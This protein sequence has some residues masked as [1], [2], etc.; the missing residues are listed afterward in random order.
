MLTYQMPYENAGAFSRAL[1]DIR[2]KDPAGRA[3]SVLFYITWVRNAR[4]LVYEVAEQIGRVFP[5]APWY[6]CEASGNI[7]DGR[8]SYGVHVTCWA[9][10]KPDTYAELV[11]LQEGTAISSM[12]DLWRL[13]G[14]RPGLRGVELIPSSTYRDLF[15]LDGETAELDEGIIIFGGASVDYDDPSIDAD[16]IA[17][18]HPMT[19][20]GMIA[21]LYYGTELNIQPAYVL[22]WKGLGRSMR[23][24]GSEGK[25]IREIDGQPAFSIYEKYLNLS[26]S[27]HDALVFPLIME[28]DGV[29]FIRTPTSFLPDYSIRMVI[30]IPEG[31]R[32]RISYGDRN[33]ILAGLY[34]KISDIAAFSPQ[35]IKIY[36]CAARRLFWGDSQVSRETM[37]LTEIASVN[38]FYTGGELLRFGKKLRVMNSTLVIVSFRE[39]SA[40]R[41]KNVL[42]GQEER[43]DKSL[44]SRLAYFTA[45]ITAEQAQQYAHEKLR[46]DVTGYMSTHEGD[47]VEMLQVFAE[48]LR[49]LYAADQVTY[50]DN[51]GTRF[52]SDIPSAARM[53]EGCRQKCVYADPG[54]QV[55]AD[56]VI[57][58]N[59]SLLVKDDVLPA[60]GCPVRA[61]LTRVVYCD[62]MP[63]G[64][65][66][67]HYT[68]GPH[69]FSDL[70][71]G[72]LA[73]FARILSLAIS[74]Y[75]AKQK[76]AL[77]QEQ[78]EQR[79]RQHE[80]GLASTLDSLS[81]DY[82]YVVYADIKQKTLFRIRS[83]AEFDALID[84]LD[85]ALS[86]SERLDAFFRNAV[87]PEDYDDFRRFTS[88]ERVRRYVSQGKACYH[89][90]R[91]VHNGKTEYYRIKI[92]PARSSLD[93]FVIGLLNINDDW[94]LRKKL[95]SEEKQLESKAII[96][97]FSQDFESISY[98]HI[99]P[100]KAWDVAVPYRVSRKLTQII[101]EWEQVQSY[102]DRLHLLADR[103]V[104][105]VDRTAF[106]AK[107]TC[108]VILT[109]LKHSDS[110][111]VSF[112]VDNGTDEYAYYQM[113]FTPV[114]DADGNMN[115]IISGLRNTDEETRRELRRQEEITGIVEERTAD[116]M[117]ANTTL[118]NISNNVLE[119]MADLVESRSAESG[120]H[121][122]RVKGFTEI[123]A[124]CVMARCPGYGLT[125]EKV[126]TIIHAS[127][128]HDIG[129]ITIPDNVLLKPG[130]LTDGEFARMK[131]HSARGAEIVRK[132]SGIWDDK[133]ISVASDICM[134]H[135]EKWDGR[136]YPSGLMGDDIPIAAQIVSIA[137]IYDALTN[138][139]CYKPAYTHDQAFDMIVGGQCGAFSER[140]LACFSAC[141]EM[142]R[143]YANNPV[144][145]LPPQAKVDIEY[146][147]PMYLR[148]QTFLADTMPLISAIAEN[149]PGAFFVYRDNADGLLVYCNAQMI[150]LA[151]CENPDDF[152][153]YT[154]NTMRG[155]VHPDD[156]PFTREHGADETSRGKNGQ[157]SLTYRIVRKNGEIVRLRDYRTFI[158]SADLGNLFFVS[159]NGTA[160]E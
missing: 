142:F 93:N 154:G 66:S 74:R 42:I 10:E 114:R 149:M 151:G 33:T 127:A 78:E 8:L 62:D 147:T 106:L 159:V 122:R 70:E 129:K 76:N 81:E 94:L 26:L 136:G 19:L 111:F 98:V 143:N 140:M 59:D 36:S 11:W 7:A 45:Q 121:I 99:E 158:R 47:P 13:C 107:T 100:E 150:R 54:H 30:G 23:V 102:M 97:S 155:L 146:K 24:S 80:A 109:N 29:E 84:A 3:G 118:N 49:Q 95:E 134:Y 79:R 96:D 160:E 44:V 119:L 14:T 77:F 61:R 69:K 105:P 123:L 132:M 2:K 17:K 104:A 75:M 60:P 50:N 125:E 41:R 103:F 133:Y 108:E 137:D 92:S 39:G 25:V 124:R 63:V 101:P 12:S 15:C 56:G 65:L 152:I 113:K 64:L 148:K 138:E 43:T 22:G 31:A 58:I 86:G 38:G 88:L 115:A 67:V 27:D 90:F 120:S 40:G 141:G 153:R 46:A 117:K 85:P 52:V 68:A 4:D 57:E 110:Y 51:N 71:R 131:E 157:E 73:E 18:G 34:G 139:R 6:G 126:Q 91:L 145:V 72:T 1:E 20:D 144:A 28:D 112:R 87:L 53:P 35:A 55:Y 16:I 83:T 9:F 135:H 48:P 32:V 156:F 37:P 82:D 128:M 89:N 21:V 130:K 5:D 116:L